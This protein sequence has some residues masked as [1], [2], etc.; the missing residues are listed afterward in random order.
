MPI[1][2]I[3]LPLKLHWWRENFRF[4]TK[5]FVSFSG[6][7]F[8]PPTSLESD[9]KFCTACLFSILLLIFFYLD[10][11]CW[12]TVGRR[13]GYMCCITMY[14]LLQKDQWRKGSIILYFIF[15]Y[16]LVLSSQFL[17]L[18]CCFSPLGIYSRILATEFI[19]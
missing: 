11:N 4:Y 8:L 1:L 14:C 12:E 2:E 5:C 17:V 16:F 10:S 6:F 15:Y 13:F 18:S 19:R 7:C 3:Q 9:S